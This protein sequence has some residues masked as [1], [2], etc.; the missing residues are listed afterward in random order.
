MTKFLV[1]CISCVT[2][3]GLKAAGFLK[4]KNSFIKYTS[5]HF[6]LDTFG[7]NHFK[8]VTSSPFCCFGFN[9]LVQS[10][11]VLESEFSFLFD[12][13]S[14]FGSFGHYKVFIYNFPTRGF[15]VFGLFCRLY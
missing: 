13:E 4:E 2:S 3:G 7:P 8:C 6:I 10:M 11:N 9:V 15:D 1:I 5:G 12:D 14:K